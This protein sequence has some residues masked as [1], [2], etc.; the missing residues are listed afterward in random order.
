[1]TIKKHLLIIIGIVIFVIIS[2][3]SLISTIFIDRLFGG[4]LE[5]SYN[6]KIEEISDYAKNFLRDKNFNKSELYN[7]DNFVGEPISQIII[8]DENENVVVESRKNMMTMHGNMMNMMQ[9][10]ERDV[11][12][13]KE[14]DEIL[15]YLFIYRIGDITGTETVNMFTKALNR[16]TFI[17][18]VIAVIIGFFITNLSSKLLSKDLK[19]T[20]KYASK[21]MTDESNIIE[22]SKIKEIKEIQNSL[23]N[24]S[25]KLKLKN[26]TRKEKADQLAHEARTPITILRTNIEGVIDGIVDID[27]DR[28]ETCRKELENLTQI[29]ENIDNILE[30]EDK[31][32]S[33]EKFNLSNEIHKI[34]KGME[35]QFKKKDIQ[36]VKDIQEDIKVNSDKGIITQSIYNLLSNS[37][38]YIDKDGKI[39]IRVARKDKIT[40]TIE[41]S[42]VGIS[43]KDK[44]KIFEPYFRG[45]NSKG[46]DGEGL[47][48]YI[49]KSN[50]LKI[51]GS[52]TVS[53]SNL[54]G[55]IFTIKL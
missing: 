26:R 49:T 50:L 45:E 30:E 25:V 48:L 13:I 38:K 27:E 21:I 7:I 2:V 53:D 24:L 18:V 12:E 40:I 1:M 4:Y 33:F 32:N 11:F 20:S 47:G 10:T 41:D 36:I 31:E 16:G 51:D 15:G 17:S 23:H 37:Y 46:L 34:I 28:L 9:G 5:D 39:K 55:A 54:G 22:N 52:I 19:K 14:N 43:D 42:G 35:L 29:V 8:L 3:N 44:E 6:Q